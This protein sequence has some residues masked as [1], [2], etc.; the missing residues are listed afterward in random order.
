MSQD[1]VQ[2]VELLIVGAG[3]S[4]IGAAIRARAQGIHDVVVLEKASSLG[5]TWR[6]NTYP[7]CACDVPSALYSYSFAQKPD[8]SRVFATQPEIL[9]YVRE[10]AVQHGVTQ[11]IHFG[12]DVLRA[13]WDTSHDHW[14]VQTTRG[15]YHARAVISCGGYLHEPLIPKLPGIERFDGPVFHSSRWDHD[16][17]LHGKRVAVIGTG[18]SAIQFVPQIQ[19]HVQKLAIFQRTP[20]WILPKP[21]VQLGGIPQRLLGLPNGTKLA[22]EFLYQRLEEFGSAFRHRAHA[23]R[24]T[25][26]RAPLACGHQRPSAA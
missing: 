20:Q 12:R 9:A 13:T 22:R 23:R 14:V 5:G 3:I 8:W 15:V 11:R 10:T 17:S 18:A 26:G 25:C 6:D 4:G 7:G 24:A 1:S 2:R 21:D 16:V 19:P